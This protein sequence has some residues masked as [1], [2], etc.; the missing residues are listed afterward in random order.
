M[1]NYWWVTRPKRRLDSIP[2]VLTIFS[3]ISLEQQWTGQRETHLK[4]ED[5]LETAGLKRVGERRDHGG[6]GGRTYAS[7]LESLGLI[8]KQESTGNIQLTL[9]GEAIMNGD[10]PVE[11]LTPQIWK[12]QFPSAYS[13]GRSVAVDPRFKIRPFL[14]LLKLL[15]DERIVFLTEEEIA[16]I[17]I[18]EAENET[19]KCYE[20]IVNRIQ[21]FRSYG[22]KS[23]RSDFFEIYTSDRIKKDRSKKIIAE[24]KTSNPFGYLLDVSNTMINWLEYTQ[25]AH[26]DKNDDNKLYILPDKREQAVKLISNLPPFIDHPE[27]KERFQ[28][29]YGID[30]KHNKDTRNLSQSQ[31]ITSRIIL[32]S[33]IRSAYIRLSMAKPI[34]SITPQIIE[35]IQS[36]TGAEE[37]L[38]EDY[39]NKNYSGGSIGAFMVS[40]HEMAFSG[41][42]K[43]TEFE[44]TTTDIFRDVFKYNAIHLGQTG[45][46]S[47]PDIL[48]ISDS[49]GYQAIIDNK[50]YSRYSITGDH[51]NRMVHNYIKGISNYSPSNYPIGFFTYIAG[52]FKDSINKQIRNEVDESGTNGSCITVDDFI[53]L[54]Q[55]AH[56]HFYSHKSLR[57][58]F[59]LNRQIV[60]SDF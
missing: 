35:S 55:K 23:L 16:K 34:Y 18:T 26:R 5:A 28:R 56:D 38:I 9:A 32:E 39:L 7:W 12:Y 60:M 20:H 31:T 41:T 21:Q 15:V 17:V 14:F 4:Y 19:N 11:V 6:G 54:V 29:R 33:K 43:A 27:Q 37:A 13:T 46:K 3:E 10:N 45:S 52:G 49:D 42:E 36:E 8:F 59:G 48:L 47:A 53:K 58:I 57:H 50:A 22:D 24:Q 2:E 44:K 1:L 25:F 40:Y 30:P 51:H